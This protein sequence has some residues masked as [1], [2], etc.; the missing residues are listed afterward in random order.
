MDL[1]REL[2]D[3]AE[4]KVLVFVPFTAALNALA[5]ELRK[6]YTVEVVYGD[7]SKMERDRIFQNFQN[8]PDPHVIVADARTMSHGLTLTAANT[9]IWYGPSPSSSTYQQ[10]NERTPRPGQKL[11]TVICHIEGSAIERVVYDRLQGKKALQGVL[12]D[13]LKGA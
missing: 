9:T 3:E 5:A 12:L 1:V 8:S 13:L 6:H 7:V 10:A 2:I 11:Q 4:A